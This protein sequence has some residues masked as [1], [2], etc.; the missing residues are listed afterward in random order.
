MVTFPANINTI[1][2][3]MFQDPTSKDIITSNYTLIL[4][5]Q[6]PH[7]YPIRG[8]KERDLGHGL[9]KEYWKQT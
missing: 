7:P 2:K 8:K 3:Y 9:E 5:S 1:W 4:D 6:A